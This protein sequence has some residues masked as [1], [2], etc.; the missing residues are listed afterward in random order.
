M[1][2][3]IF[4][5]TPASQAEIW[6]ERLKIVIADSESLGIETYLYTSKCWSVGLDA[7]M[8]VLFRFLTPSLLA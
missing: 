3:S 7:A 6:G 8:F 4:D 5:L 2:F 1:E